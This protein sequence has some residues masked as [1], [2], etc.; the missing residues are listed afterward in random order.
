MCQWN[1]RRKEDFPNLAKDADPE[2]QEAKQ[3]QKKINE[4]KF[5]PK[6]I[7]KFLKT[8][9]KEKTLRATKEKLHIIYRGKAIQMIM[10]FT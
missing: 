8:E 6:D 3:I 2:T 1:P 5:T 10:N 7:V 4:K 9:Y